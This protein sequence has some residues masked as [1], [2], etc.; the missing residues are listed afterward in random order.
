MRY[1]CTI[2]FTILFFTLVSAQREPEH[3]W[4]SDADFS[5]IVPD[6]QPAPASLG[7]A[8]RQYRFEPEH[9]F[10]GNIGLRREW[11]VGEYVGLSAGLSLGYLRIDQDVTQN[12]CLNDPA[13]CTNNDRF[14]ETEYN[15]FSLGAPLGVRGFPMGE[16]SGV[17]VGGTLKPTF[18]IS[19][20][21]E[22]EIPGRNQGEGAVFPV[23]EV[24]TPRMSLRWRTE[25]GWQ[26]GHLDG[27]YLSVFAGGTF[28]EQFTPVPPRAGS[29]AV[30]VLGA[31][32]LSL[33]IAFG[34]TFY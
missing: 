33:G 22:G 25:L 19:D 3:R 1:L 27:Y 8:P 32:Y 24:N 17:Y 30:Q 7:L 34:K 12:L 31:R 15:S 4:L 23:A 20:G 2:A 29:P 9:S 11:L 21:T 5:L 16:G 28:G 10:A 14:V 6:L 18:N 26:S 13:N